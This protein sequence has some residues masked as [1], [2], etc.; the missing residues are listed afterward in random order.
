MKLLI[1]VMKFPIF[2][3]I[4]NIFSSNLQQFSIHLKI[5][6]FGCEINKG[7]SGMFRSLSTHKI[8]SGYNF[9]HITKVM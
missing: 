6:N 8:M 1:Q 9:I 2:E 3:K 4:K 5:E 7:L